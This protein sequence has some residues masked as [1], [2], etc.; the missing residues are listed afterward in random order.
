MSTT[1]SD[2][3]QRTAIR[4][5]KHRPMAAEQMPFAEAAWPIWR[6]VRRAA[7]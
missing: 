2:P 6:P 5:G 3:R 7:S 1:S 4:S